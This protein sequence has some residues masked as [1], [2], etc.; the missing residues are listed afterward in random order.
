MCV[1]VC[2]WEG[3]DAHVSRLSIASIL[4]RWHHRRVFDL[5]WRFDHVLSL[6]V[7]AQARALLAGV[8]G[9]QIQLGFSS[10]HRHHLCVLQQIGSW[11]GKYGL[12]KHLGYS[13]DPDIA[14][15]GADS[16]LFTQCRK[17]YGL[18]IGYSH[19]AEILRN[20]T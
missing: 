5:H 12:S 19:G 17:P 14:E 2:V 15:I 13:H 8:Y 6:P 3:A 20:C 16:W 9:L 10:V 18:K 4:I 1:C 11:L 7:D